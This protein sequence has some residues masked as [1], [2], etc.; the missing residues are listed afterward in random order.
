MG[1]VLRRALAGLRSWVVDGIEPA[2]ADPIETTDTRIVR[3][4]DGIAVGGVRTPAVDAPDRILSGAGTTESGYLCSLF[5]TTQPLDAARFRAR[6]GSPEAYRDAVVA[7][8][9]ASVDAGYLLRVDADQ[10]VEEA[11]RSTA[12]A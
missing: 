4:E 9:D 11:R 3:D 10:L 8:A 2:R 5:G 7:A 1:P 6:Y 12:G